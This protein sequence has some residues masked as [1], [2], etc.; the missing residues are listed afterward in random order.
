MIDSLN[1]HMIATMGFITNRSN[2][3]NQA[4]IDYWPKF[5]VNVIIDVGIAIGIGLK[6]MEEWQVRFIF[7][8]FC[9]Y[10]SIIDFFVCFRINQGMVSD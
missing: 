3:E 10:Y 1:T 7:S 6:T 9:D 8:L 2:I 4:F 5:C